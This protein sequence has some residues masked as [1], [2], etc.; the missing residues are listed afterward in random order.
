MTQGGFSL[1]AGV[2]RAL[3]GHRVIL[4][5]I[6]ECKS[7]GEV[8]V[9]G[10]C[11][12]FGAKLIEMGHFECVFWDQLRI[13]ATSHDVFMFLD[14]INQFVSLAIALT[15]PSPVDICNIMMHLV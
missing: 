10:G 4:W 3:L 14:W 5:A 11:L 8:D 1:K 6:V 9:S 15:K 12:L 13:V 2:G 7:C